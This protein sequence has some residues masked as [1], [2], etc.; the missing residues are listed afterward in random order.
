MDS[1]NQMNYGIEFKVKKG[2]ITN[3]AFF[4]VSPNIYLLNFKYVGTINCLNQALFSHNSMH[5]NAEVHGKSFELTFGFPNG[6]AFADGDTVLSMCKKFHGRFMEH[7]TKTGKL[8]GKIT[9]LF[10]HINLVKIKKEKNI[11]TRE[12]LAT[13]NTHLETHL[14]TTNSTIQLL[15]TKVDGV[16]EEI[17]KI[18]RKEAKHQDDLNSYNNQITSEKTKMKLEQKFIE[19]H[20]GSL[21][22]IVKVSQSEIDTNWSSFKVDLKKLIDIHSD[23]DYYKNVLQAFYHAY[24]PSTYSTV[25]ENVMK[26]LNSFQI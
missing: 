22:S 12:K 11:N 3:P 8:Q 14:R 23:Q 24:K 2:V 16:N 6:W 1:F 26:S 15:R 13:F 7:E 5:F 19:D 4:L 20:N 21:Q 18:G 17:H 25:A 9:Q 10:N